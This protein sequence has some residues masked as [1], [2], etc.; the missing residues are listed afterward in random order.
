MRK[1]NTKRYAIVLMLLFVQIFTLSVGANN[2]TKDWFLIKKGGTP[3][4]PSDA[5]RISQ[6]G[7]YYID[8]EANCDGEKVVYLT[9]DAGYENGNVERILDVL[10]E[11]KVQGAFFILSNIIRKNPST[12]KRMAEEGHLVCNHTKN[13]KDMSKLT[14][15][16]M[17]LNLKA[18][19][20]LY[21][22]TTGYQMTKY[23]RF[24]EGKYSDERLE[25][26]NSL[27]YK[28]FFWSIAYEDWDNSK[29]ISEDYAIKKLSE[30]LHPGAIVLLHPTTNVNV[31]I[32]PRLID[33][34]QDE[35]YRFASIDELVLKSKK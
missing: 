19:E 25:Y 17:R 33:K 10:K 14:N 9:F 7:G 27:G 5:D 28:T 29:P 34:W 18:L 3:G 12:V 22:E 35:G 6:L 15:E 16:E 11:K 31:K 4:F 21:Y 13:H 26:C 32:L 30:Q 1:T 20:D 2:T 24:P 23:F 8:K